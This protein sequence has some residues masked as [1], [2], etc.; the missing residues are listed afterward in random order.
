MCVYEWQVGCG[1]G[2]NVTEYGEGR[3]SLA[4]GTQ[5]AL[6]VKLKGPI[7]PERNQ[8][9]HEGLSP[10]RHQRLGLYRRELSRVEW[11]ASASREVGSAR[12][13]RNTEIQVMAGL[14]GDLGQVTPP[15][16]HLPRLPGGPNAMMH[17]KVIIVQGAVQM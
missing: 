1:D 2:E 15:L 3:A 9:A 13:R 12:S 17:E 8:A 5:G 7:W 16:P 4:R 10:G 14:T 11:E 6:H